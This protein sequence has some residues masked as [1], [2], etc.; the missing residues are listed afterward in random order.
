MASEEHKQDASETLLH[1]AEVG[2]VE[3]CKHL[4]KDEN[5]DPNIQNKD[6]YTSLHIAAYRGYDQVCRILLECEKTDVNIQHRK[7]RCT[8]L[9]RSIR[10]ADKSVTVVEILTESKHCNPNLADANGQTPLHLAAATYGSWK[11]LR[12]ILTTQCDLN[13]EDKE[14]RT[15]LDVALHECY[16]YRAEMLV[17][18]KLFN[19]SHMKQNGST[20]LHKA[21]TDGHIKLCKLM[22][23][24]ERCSL[25]VQDKS[26]DTPLHIAI[27]KEKIELI[28]TI[29]AHKECDLTIQNNNGETPLHIA[30]SVN[31][32]SITEVLIKDLR[33]NI[34]LQSMNKPKGSTPL[35]MAV[36]LKNIKLCHLILANPNCNSS[37]QDASGNTPLHLAIGKGMLNLVKILLAHMDVYGLNLRNN[38]GR[39]P[40]YIAV[41]NGNRDLCLMLIQSKA[42]P[43]IPN[44]VSGHYPIHIAASAPSGSGELCHVLLKCEQTDPNVVNNVGNTPLHLA[45]LCGNEAAVKVLTA[46]GKCSPNVAN[47]E[48]H[49]PL[50]FSA[51]QNNV[52]ICEA[53]MNTQICNLDIQNRN[54]ET[55][56]HMALRQKHVSIAQILVKD[57]HWN[58]SL[59]DYNGSTPLHIAVDI[60]EVNMC[61]QIL[62]AHG[63]S[64]PNIQYSSRSTSPHMHYIDLNLKTSD[65]RTPLH[66]SAHHG[67]VEICKLLLDAG[68]NPNLKDNDGLIPVYIAFNQAFDGLARALLKCKLTDPSIIDPTTGNTQLHLAA[69]FQDEAAVD[70]LKT[71]ECSPNI[72]NMKGSTS[73]HIAATYG[74]VRICKAI[75]NIQDCNPNIRDAMGYYNTPLHIA[76][77]KG[78][79]ELV[80]TILSHDRCDL[81]IPNRDLNTPLHLA[82]CLTNMTIAQI[83]IK[84]KRCNPSHKNDHS[85]TPLHMA[86]QICDVELCRLI[87]ANEKCNPN[88]QDASGNTPLHIATTKGNSELVQA[89][90]AHKQCDLGIKNGNTETP[91]FVAIR[92]GNMAIAQSLAISTP[93]MCKAVD[94]SDTD[95]Y[96]LSEQSNPNVQDAMG[97]TLLHIAV[98]NG[99]IELVQNFV[100]H[101]QCDP[102]IQNREDDTPLHLAFYLMNMSIVQILVNDERCNPSLKDCH[103]ITP[104]HMA[105]HQCNLKLCK[106]ML[107]KCNLNIPD[108]IGNTPL[109]IAV[110]NGNTELV[111]TILYHEQCDLNIPNSDLNTPLHL[112]LCLT[113][114]EIAQTLVNDERCNPSLQNCHSLTP[115]HM[116]VEKCDVEL[117]RLILASKYCNPNVRNASGNTPLHIAAMDGNIELLQAITGHQQCDSNIQNNIGR[118]P[119]HIAAEKEDIGNCNMLMTTGVNPNIQDNGGYIPLHVAS[120]RGN[121][122]LCKRF[123]QNELLHPNSV[124]PNTGDT[125][126][127]I[128]VWC[129]CET[130]FERFTASKSY[131]PGS[132]PFH[133][134]VTIGSVNIQNERGDTS[135]HL[136]LSLKNMKFAQILVKDKYCNP[137]L[138][139]SD[140]STQLHLAAQVGNSELF[141]IMLANEQC[142]PNIQD[143]SGNTPL[144]IAAMQGKLDLVRSILLHCE[145]NMNL[146]NNDEQTPLH[147]AAELGNED[148]CR[149]LLANEADPN[150][151]DTNGYTA[152]CTAT[153]HN[154]LNVVQTLAACKRCNPNI[155]DYNGNTPLHIAAGK[156]SEEFCLAILVNKQCDL[157]VVN[158]VGSTVLHTACSQASSD[159][160][161]VLITDK[162]LNLADDD[163]NTPLHLAVGN[164]NEETCNLLLSNEQC[165]TSVKNKHLHTP[166][167]MSIRKTQIPIA[168][169]IIVHKTCDPTVHDS[170]GNTPLHLACMC[171]E[172]DSC[173]V[174]IAEML[175]SNVSVNLE[176][177]NNAGQ[178][179]V[180][181]T[182]N[183][184]LIQGI[185]HFTECQI[186]HSVQTYIKVFV[187]GN[188]ETGKSTLIKSIC[189]E[190]AKW[191]KVLPSSLRRVRNVPHHTAG[192]VPRTFTSKTFGNTVLYD[193]A[194]QHEYYSSH[195]AVIEHTLLAS[196]PAFVVVLNISEE[197]YQI[198]EQLKYWW[199]FIDNHAARSTA[200]PH[201]ILV[202][203]HADKVKSRGG[204][205]EQ[206]MSFLLKTLRQLSC[207]FHF[208]DHMHIAF[209]CRK[210]VSKGLNKLC[211][212]LNQSCTT[213]RKSADIDLRCHA[214]FAFLLQHFHG[215][216]TC[217]IS[218]IAA[219]V[220]KEDAL[221]PQNPEDLFQLIS[222]LSDRGLV[223]LVQRESTAN[224]L[225][226]LQKQALLSEING[227][228]FA[229]E[230]FEQHQH[231][232]S[233][234][235]VPL[236][237]IRQTFPKYKPEMIIEYLTHLEYCFKVDDHETLQR[238]KDEAMVQEDYPM[239]KSEEYYLFPALVSIENPRQVWQQDSTIHYQCGWYYKCIGQN[240]F[241]TTRFLHVLILRLAFSCALSVDTLPTWDLCRRCSIWKHGIGWLDRDGIE[242]VV[243]VGLQC[244][245]VTVM[246][247][248]QRGAEVKCARLRSAIIQKVLQIRTEFCPAVK[249][250]E[251]MMHPSCIIYPFKDSQS[252]VLYSIKEI[253]NAVTNCQINVL[254]QR[255]GNWLK[256]SELLLFEPYAGVDGE[257]LH[258]LLRELFCKDNSEKRMDE[259]FLVR[260]ANQIHPRMELYEK[261][262]NPYP[263]T[264]QDEVERESTPA[265]KCRVLL[266]SLYRRI[267]P[268]YENFHKE[269]DKFSIF[270]GRDPMVRATV[271]G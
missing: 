99:H 264:Y 89:I 207:T 171:A 97:N 66:I 107:A 3:K 127:H 76:I 135:L 36:S 216:T 163:G 109:H 81:N 214:L 19:P 78:N 263:G 8:P 147:I 80:Q 123:L 225:V 14:G 267:I 102:N 69:K 258:E 257:L 251:A 239:D 195:A 46:D 235:V 185:N 128:A 248:C 106:A 271:L 197:E 125:P 234:G 193:L 2:D 90:V 30:L 176:C 222:S 34:A 209:D 113:N 98:A 86:V 17:R 51:A 203:S 227:V 172:N 253:A 92:L 229:P 141:K 200:P 152:L 223:F 221:L 116:A 143:A 150:V 154:R 230:Y 245:V 246:M 178:T 64:N 142:N 93:A 231:S 110:I 63:Q 177:V 211:T 262:I 165:D 101:D 250:S 21:V 122:E 88:I 233:T 153:Y 236:S 228:I 53:L 208:A 112:A 149:L 4:L 184:Q 65:G 151:Q 82:L 103:G 55:A 220:K 204:S 266:Q 129:E 84:D 159:V 35:H 254:D 12:T 26:G 45:I 94:M 6:G 72:L 213:L 83:L 189:K 155:Q 148:I 87:L 16:P 188:A 237:R 145:C 131:N 240:Q 124:D 117:C 174:E 242:T 241:L 249:M 100:F 22:L 247:R 85:F 259:S 168:K 48:G 270:C 54:Q 38:S 95:L 170:D 58:P 179:P 187:V 137:F 61:R 115:L 77:E 73:L 190:A 1:A 10:F 32:V 57:K 217:S 180:E 252:I 218:D 47:S 28:H 243:E 114:T 44:H 25:N 144:H 158:G 161:K 191:R 43:H 219:G 52:C 105:V 91:L 226:V 166:L 15:P 167:H 130:A 56:L 31:N 146:Q 194:G 27:R 133:P 41:K 268:T 169:S 111:R 164:G 199:S 121:K 50:H 67:N 232:E 96:Q 136:A 238:I 37:L 192:I 104:L 183:Y 5:V 196:P 256:V 39:T 212:I 60:G 157:H 79:T 265:G 138:K 33:C 206:R 202:G 120:S 182:T 119:L 49:T 175:L 13:V 210:T 7:S 20:P 269:L 74:N 261:A 75:M 29:L 9:H 118:T 62:L 162:I 42:F 139:N 160:V 140:G 126:L 224:S 260:L 24:S 108:A 59:Q 255:G 134:P 68:A 215:S 173:M 181:L 40:L 70:Y 186:K 11:L 132:A 201:V 205:V 156:D 18:D 71:Q 23:V 198:S 244:Q